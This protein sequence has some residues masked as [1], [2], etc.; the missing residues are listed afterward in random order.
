MR[1]TNNKTGHSQLM[2][3]SSLTKD[4]QQCYTEERRGLYR[5]LQISE[6][7]KHIIA[8]KN[9]I[10]IT[11]YSCTQKWARPLPIYRND[12][13]IQ[14]AVTTDTIYRIHGYYTPCPHARHTVA[15]GTTYRNY[16]WGYTVPIGTVSTDP[17]PGR[18]WVSCRW[19]SR[20][21]AG[22]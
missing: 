13:I 4:R 11:S 20:F 16:R 1:D 22:W 7:E 10:K 5:L 14:Y 6:R 8:N 15:T 18:R 3:L 19:A 17:H 2:R 21:P 12:V 9:M